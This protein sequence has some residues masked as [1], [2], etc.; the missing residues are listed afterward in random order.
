VGMWRVAGGSFTPRRLSTS[1][2]DHPTSPWGRS[3]GGD[4]HRGATISPYHYCMTCLHVA[5]DVAETPRHG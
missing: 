1:P 3:D 4:E 5:S 2:T